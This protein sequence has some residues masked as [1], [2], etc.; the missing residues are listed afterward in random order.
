MLP[1]FFTFWTGEGGKKGKDK[2]RGWQQTVQ[3]PYLTLNPLP[4]DQKKNKVMCQDDKRRYFFFSSP[5]PLNHAWKRQNHD[6]VRDSM[7]HWDWS[8]PIVTQLKNKSQTG[9]AAGDSISLQFSRGLDRDGLLRTRLGA[10]APFP[11]SLRQRKKK[12]QVTQ[13]TCRLKRSSWIPN[14]PFDEMRD[15][16][17]STVSMLKIKQGWQKKR[18][19]SFR[20]HLLTAVCSWWNDSTHS[21][22]CWETCHIVYVKTVDSIINKFHGI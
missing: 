10:S 5:W 11:W 13:G 18:K 16:N 8:R 2:G 19:N 3:V 12:E 6:K 9:E 1:S 15:H 4:K 21:S 20:M 17:C 22:H 7:Q 14:F